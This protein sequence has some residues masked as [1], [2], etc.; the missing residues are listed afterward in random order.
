[1]AGTVVVIVG[2]AG[3]L[4]SKDVTVDGIRGGFVGVFDRRPVV[5][6]GV[7]EVKR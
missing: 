1:V 7:A 2:G 6:S 5:S 4:C 3:R